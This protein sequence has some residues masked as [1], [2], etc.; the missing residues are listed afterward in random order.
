M[1]YTVY[2]FIALC[3]LRLFGGSNERSLRKLCIPYYF[4]FELTYVLFTKTIIIQNLCD[5]IL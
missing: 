1:V 4:S 2:I 3:A 5:N